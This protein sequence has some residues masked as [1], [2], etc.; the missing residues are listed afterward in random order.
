MKLSAD[1]KNL[2]FDKVAVTSAMDK[3]TA[4]GLSRAGALVRI[5]AIRSIK[6]TKRKISR[7]G[8]QPKTHEPS[9]NRPSMK[10]IYFHFDPANQTV[11]IGAIRYSTRAN[12]D[13][14]VSVP[15]ILEHGGQSGIYERRRKGGTW[16][17]ASRRSAL[18]PYQ[19]ERVRMVTIAARPFMVP[20]LAKA[21]PRIDTFF[22]QSI[23]GNR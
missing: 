17:Q 15:S 5:I 18:R 4:R 7:P 9:G 6:R 2:F 20:A 19:E 23:K 10:E 14:P 21:I 13:T 16:G 22:Q 1:V 8:E 3:A 11:V 12:A